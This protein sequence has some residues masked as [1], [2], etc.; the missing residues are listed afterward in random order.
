MDLGD[1][2]DFGNFGDLGVVKVSS[3]SLVETGWSSVIGEEGLV[4]VVMVEDWLER[5]R[6]RVGVGYFLDPNETS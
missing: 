1:L 2:G 3:V 5:A 4:P 6:V